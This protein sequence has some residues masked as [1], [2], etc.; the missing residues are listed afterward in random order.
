M[1]A[2]A[3][4]PYPLYCYGDQA[5]GKNGRR[6]QAMDRTMGFMLHHDDIVEEIATK[7]QGKIDAISRYIIEAREMP[8]QQWRV[9]FFDGNEPLSQY[10]ARQ[11]DLRLVKCPHVEPRRSG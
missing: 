3:S 6:G 10:F 5:E 11:E 4:G 2:G 8:P 7:R 1:N 9:H